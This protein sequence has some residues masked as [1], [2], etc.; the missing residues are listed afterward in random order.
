M[1]IGRFFGWVFFFCAGSVLVR[2]FLAWHDRQAIT[3]LSLGGL[4]TTLDPDGFRAAEAAVTR[5]AP[6][7]WT[8]AL[9][10][11]SALWAFPVFAIVSLI[12]LWTCR[13]VR[14]RRHR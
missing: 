14:R 12:L 5:L 1:V 3:P 13:R 10:P 11:F 4:W 2:E 9:G 8:W 6:W 7:L